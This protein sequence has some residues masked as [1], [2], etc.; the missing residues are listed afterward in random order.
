LTFKKYLKGKTERDALII[1][2]VRFTSGANSG[3]FGRRKQKLEFPGIG[4]KN[5]T[6]AIEPNID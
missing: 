4:Q 6:E 3:D 2:L 5:N 1:R